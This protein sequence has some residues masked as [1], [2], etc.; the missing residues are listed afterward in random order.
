MMVTK[1]WHY[2]FPPKHWTIINQFE[3]LNSRGEIIEQVWVLQDQFGNIKFKRL[4]RNV[5]Y[6]V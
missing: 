6:D 2:L 5:F 3:T 1:F 4:H